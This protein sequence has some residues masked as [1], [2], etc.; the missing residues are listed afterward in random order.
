MII[1]SHVHVTTDKNYF[2]Y[3]D[4]LLNRL[5]VEMASSDI[6]MAFP[7]LNPKL[8]FFRCPHDCSF[9]CLAT[10]GKTNNNLNNCNCNFPDRHRVCIH[11]KKGKLI[12]ACKT[13]GKLILETNVDPIRDYNIRL[14]NLT[15]PYRSFLKPILY[16]SLCKSTLQKEIDF[17][18]K[19]YKGDFVGFKFHPWND[20]VSVSNF[21]VN[22]SKPILIHTG[23]RSIES[24]KN[25]ITFAQ[26][27]PSVRVV[28]AHA[29]SL[30]DEIL[31]QIAKM[32]NVYIDCCPSVF[33]FKNKTSCLTCSQDVSCPEDIYYKIL[34][35]VPI[36]KILFGTDAPWGNS[37]QEL[38]VVRNLKIPPRFK[39][40]IL[41]KNAKKVY[42]TD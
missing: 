39:E 7:T 18:E 23:K 6:D 1:N 19:K 11:E 29:A 14:I 41:Y 30:D 27:N 8:P 28:I 16:L 9:S 22:T 31:I 26:N 24:A 4:Y 42:L 3:N 15:K 12:L 5:I 21:N 36:D 13:C 40:Y 34:S 32:K 35:I 17:F 10:S 25:A 20:Q 37:F 33:M 2:F 38:E